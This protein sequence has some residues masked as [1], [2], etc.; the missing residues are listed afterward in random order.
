MTR[1]QQFGWRVA[2]DAIASSLKWVQQYGLPPSEPKM[3]H[4]WKDS[5]LSDGKFLVLYFYIRGEDE[6]AR[7]VAEDA[8][9]Y[10]E[11]YFFGP[12]RAEAPTGNA[13]NQPPD[14]EYWHQQWAQDDKF[15]ESACFASCLGDWEFVKR[16]AEYMSTIR[17]RELES[18]VPGKKWIDFPDGRST[19]AWRLALAGVIHGLSLDSEL[20]PLVDIVTSGKQKRAQLLLAF[21]TAVVRG[22]DDELRGAAGAYFDY[23]VKRQSKS[24]MITDKVMIEGTLLVNYARHVGRELT[25]PASVGE[26]YITLPGRG[27]DRS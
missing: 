6:R 17:W 8:V 18:Y 20:R 10:A 7:Q 11:D 26:R 22:G 15:V 19:S 9:R 16:L 2:D 21:L 1:E 4:T 3:L 24:D 14:P 25:V 23:Y 12:W 13:M 5:R 27:A